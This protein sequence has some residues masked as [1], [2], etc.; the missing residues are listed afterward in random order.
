[1]SLWYKGGF[2]AL[3]ESIIGGAEYLSHK[4]AVCCEPRISIG[5]HHTKAEEVEQSRPDE[6]RYSLNEN[7][8]A[9]RTTRG[10]SARSLNIN[11]NKVTLEVGALLQPCQFT[12]WPHSDRILQYDS[13]VS[14]LPLLRVKTRKLL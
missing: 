2:H 4:R 11:N 13:D 10:G 6:S 7:N 1:M 5:P 12:C 8:G 3:K 14:L 9:P